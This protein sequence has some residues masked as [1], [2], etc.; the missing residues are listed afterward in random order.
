M[1]VRFGMPELSWSW[2]KAVA[3]A[4]IEYF[5]SCQPLGSDMVAICTC[6]VYIY[7]LSK[8][9][10]LLWFHGQAWPSTS[11]WDLR[12]LWRRCGTGLWPEWGRPLTS[13]PPNSCEYAATQ[14]VLALAKSGDAKRGFLLLTRSGEIGIYT[15]HGLQSAPFAW[16]ELPMDRWHQLRAVGR[17]GS[18]T[19]F[20]NGE[21]VAQIPAEPDN[22]WPERFGGDTDARNPQGAGFLRQISFQVQ[23][24]QSCQAMWSEGSV[25][26]AW[27][28]VAWPRP[29]PS[30][31]QPRN[32]TKHVQKGK[33]WS[34]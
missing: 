24:P 32:A 25:N 19:F 11:Q 34:W 13:F 2:P 14:R 4:K 6:T 8:E 17:N 1:I 9:S 12:V 7:I 18:T 23:T 29:S 16:H 15:Q 20:C 21:Q 27:S 5:E 28:E 22:H 10:M 31:A 33:S 3:K 30:L 26:W